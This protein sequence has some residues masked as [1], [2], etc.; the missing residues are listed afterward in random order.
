MKKKL[1]SLVLAGAMVASTSVS[2]FA[3][4]DTVETGS[5]TM[6]QGEND[7]DIEIGITGNVLDDN[8]NVKPGTI[9]VTVPT[10]V[11][12]TVMSDGTLNSPEM[13]ITNNSTEKISIVAKAFED[14]NGENDIEIVKR[15]DFSG[16]KSNVD[17]K[18]IWLQLT[19]GSQYLALTSED[20]GT[21]YDAE[22]ASPI[23]DENY[24]I[25]KISEKGSKV[26]K[27]DGEG[28]TSGSAP[29][30]I[31]DKFKLVLKVK[32]DRQS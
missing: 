9:S 29:D 14:G 11:T 3:A 22:Y 26:L 8:G 6:T 32:R 20:N 25:C 21:M 4:T 10:A 12:F 2:A 30:A 7:K 27:L 28:G 1:L 16:G 5:V 23:E 24:E 17:R 13:T 31:R 19:G 15:S 18:K